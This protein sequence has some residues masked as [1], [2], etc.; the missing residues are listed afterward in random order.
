MPVKSDFRQVVEVSEDP[1]F[2][3]F[4]ARSRSAGLCPSCRPNR[5]MPGVRN[6]ELKIGA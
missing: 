2:V 5:E 6:G 1:F 3:H 4:L